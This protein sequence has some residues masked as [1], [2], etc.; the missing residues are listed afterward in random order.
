MAGPVARGQMGRSLGGRASV[1]TPSA[2]GEAAVAAGGGR[3]VLTR[4]GADAE[5]GEHATGR[6]RASADGACAVRGHLDLKLG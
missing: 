2:M 1:E 5:G 4:A 6:A 3:Y